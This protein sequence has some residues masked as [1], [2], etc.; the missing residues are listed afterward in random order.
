[1][2]PGV[3]WTVVVPLKA[4]PAAK[5]RLAQSLGPQVHEDVV[6]ALR[7]DTLDA[8]RRAG[9]VDR[10]VVVSDRPLPEEDG[11]GADAFIV[12]RSRG[13][14]GALR[15]A[16]D[17]AAT[18]WPE[19]GIAALVGDLPALTAGE[20]EDALER[21]AGHDRAFAPDAA[22]TGTTLLTAAPGRRL[23]PSFG[24]SSATRHARLAVPVEAGPGLR[25]DVDSAADLLAAAALRLG[26]ATTAALERHGLL[27][28]ALD[29]A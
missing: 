3:Q 6:R 19:E 18:R 2:A 16:A 10:L 28:G 1:V 29:R 9:T 7:V 23:R 21:A 15:D 12:Q 22:G 13:L 26:P 8:V 27:R 11:L 17:V 25:C 24:A 20:L 5:S 4:L 14:N